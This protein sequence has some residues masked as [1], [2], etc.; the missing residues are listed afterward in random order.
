MPR[1]RKTAIGPVSIDI[2]LS[3]LRDTQENIETAQIL[4]KLLQEGGYEELKPDV[5][6]KI[7]K[8]KTE[9]QKV[10]TRISRI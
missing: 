8:L 10:R 9:S 3:K 1:E 5:Y 7:M 6:D 2:L 4:L